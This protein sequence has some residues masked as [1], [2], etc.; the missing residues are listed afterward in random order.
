M[1]A[2]VRKRGENSYQLNVACGYD[3]K[4]KQIVK[5]TTVTAANITEAKR[6]YNRFAAE[7]LDGNDASCGRMTLPQ[8]YDYYK[9]NYA[10][11]NNEART[12]AYNDYLFERIKEYFA[13]KRLDKIEVKDILAFYR[14]L[15]DQ[16]SKKDSNKKLSNST[17]KKY[18]V[19]LKTMF[20]KAVEWN[21]LSYN[22]VDKA[23]TGVPKV[24]KTVKA[25]SKRILRPFSRPLREKQ[26]SIDLWSY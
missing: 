24:E 26:Q 25:I 13:K 3:P 7:V 16:P 2:K 22:P 15:A 8:F 5:S 6:L 12:L 21:F 17:I 4:G 1:P 18:H 9:E 23:K 14:H 19:L 20:N 10:N 11:L